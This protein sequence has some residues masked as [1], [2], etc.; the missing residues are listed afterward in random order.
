[1]FTTAIEGLHETYGTARLASYGS[2]GWTLSY[3]ISV[4]TVSELLS[5]RYTLALS[6]PN[7]PNGEFNAVSEY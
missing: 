1:M 5:T 6:G 7:L 4:C 3:G 2:Y